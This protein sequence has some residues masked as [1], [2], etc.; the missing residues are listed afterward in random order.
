M[1]KV[2]SKFKVRKEITLLSFPFSLSRLCVDAPDIGVRCSMWRR[3]LCDPPV[4]IFILSTHRGLS[5]RT[6]K[7]SGRSRRIAP[8]MSSHRLIRSCVTLVRTVPRQE[9]MDPT[10]CELRSPARACRTISSRGE[11]EYGWHRSTLG[12]GGGGG[13]RVQQHIPLKPHTPHC[14]HLFSFCAHDHMAELPFG[15]MML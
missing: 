7:N 15:D 1:F 10:H 3:S 6:E 11:R 12:E 13:R 14:D 8:R 4:F 2:D 5:R 9:R